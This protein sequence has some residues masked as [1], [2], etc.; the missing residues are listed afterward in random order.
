MRG[1]SG[2]VVP[3]LHPTLPSVFLIE[4]CNAKY[5][6]NDEH[7]EQDREKLNELSSLSS[8]ATHVKRFFGYI[9]IAE[10]V[11]RGDDSI[12]ERRSSG[13]DVSL[14]HSTSGFELVVEN[15]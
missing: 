2:P 4:V 11:V 12:G 7:R 5:L 10:L 6:T 13:R 9:A 3:S 8:L 1:K 14:L 15:R